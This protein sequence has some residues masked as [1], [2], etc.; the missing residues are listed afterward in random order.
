MVVRRSRLTVAVVAL[1]LIATLPQ[2]ASADFSSG[3]YSHSSGACNSS[4]DPISLVL[5]GYG[6]FYSAARARLQARL[7]WSGDDSATQYANSHGYCTNMD[8]ES[9]S[10]CD[11]CSRMHVR[12]NQTHH[13]DTLNRYEWSAPGFSDT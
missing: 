10:G 4:V 12:Y 8:G 5:Y 3:S 7:G 1:G 9:Y 13:K 11:Y 6:A 2:T